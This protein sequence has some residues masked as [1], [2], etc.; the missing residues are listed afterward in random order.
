MAANVSSSY[1]GAPPAR[2]TGIRVVVGVLGLAVLVVGIVLLFN[3]VT[4][5]HALALLIGVGFVL[6]GLME[7]AVGWASGHRGTAVVLGAV[8]VVGGICAM[9]W[10]GVTLRVLV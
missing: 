3:P 1:A 10:P 7:V 9:V 4:A 2:S 6:A 8:L 5:A